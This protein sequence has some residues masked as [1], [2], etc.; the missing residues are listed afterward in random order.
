MK[1]CRKCGHKYEGRQCPPCKLKSNAKHKKKKRE[2]LRGTTGT[3]M[4][5]PCPHGHDGLRYNNG[6]ACVTCVQETAKKLW[7]SSGERWRKIRREKYATD[8]GRKDRRERNLKQNYGLTIAAYDAMAEAQGN[9]CAIC[10]GEPTRRAHEHAQ[11]FSVD[12]DHK[13]GK[14]R[15]LLC[16]ACNVGIGSMRDDADI[17]EAAA[18]YIRKHRVG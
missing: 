15:A 5:K 14:V 11:L 3:H 12:H 9:R 6:N 4:G 1:T 7:E 16:H 18:A 10:N 17:L 8:G 2:N 13:T